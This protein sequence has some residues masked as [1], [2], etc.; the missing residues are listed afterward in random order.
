MYLYIIF[1]FFK[2]VAKNVNFRVFLFDKK[3][4]VYTDDFMKKVL[5]VYIQ[6]FNPRNI[7]KKRLQMV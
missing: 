3:F 7:T 5:G 1:Y 6:S 2:R 4:M